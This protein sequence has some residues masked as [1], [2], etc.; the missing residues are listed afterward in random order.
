MLFRGLHIIIICVWT[1]QAGAPCGTLPA[2][3]GSVR[4]NSLYFPVVGLWHASSLAA[5]TKEAGGVSVCPAAGGHQLRTE[6]EADRRRGSQAAA[7]QV[8]RAEGG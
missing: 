2:K 5:C 6:S 3:E 8:P 1:G 4:V 7:D